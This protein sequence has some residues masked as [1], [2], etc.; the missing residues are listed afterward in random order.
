M[1]FTE[2]S[3]TALKQRI[4]AG[5]DLVLLDVRQPEEHAEQHIPNSILIP[6]GELPARLDEIEQY[7]DRELIVYCRSGNR[8]GQACMFLSMQGFTNPVNLEGGMLQW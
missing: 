8:S 2:I 1:T 3:S 4:A 6:L 5:E 7:R